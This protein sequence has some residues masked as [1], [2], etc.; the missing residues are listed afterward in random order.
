MVITGEV[1]AV[2]ALHG[3]QMQGVTGP[4]RVVEHVLEHGFDVCRDDF[5]KLEVGEGL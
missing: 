2:E 4:Q 1:E 3:C 5:H